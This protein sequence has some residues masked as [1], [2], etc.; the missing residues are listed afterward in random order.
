MPDRTHTAGGGMTGLEALA[1]RRD[2]RPA[3]IWYVLLVDAVAVVLSAGAAA[4]LDVDRRGWLVFGVLVACVL[5]YTE[6]SRPIERE[7][8]TLTDRPHLDVRAVW[9]FASVLTLPP[10]LTALVIVICH[11]YPW[12]RVR[13]YV[14]YREVFGVAVAVIGAFAAKLLLWLTGFD[15]FPGERNAAT[16]GVAIAA[17]LVFLA[18]TVVL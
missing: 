7:C 1:I 3:L 9:I 5:V 17:A 4:R 18:L 10:A 11:G 15:D 2:L 12:L 14:P 8:R 6:V 16:F 13:R